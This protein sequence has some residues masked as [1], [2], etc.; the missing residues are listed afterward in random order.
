MT[1]DTISEIPVVFD[2]L[3]EALIGIVHRPQVPAVVGVL[4]VVAGGPQYRAG[5]GRGMVSLAR[6]LACNGVP[7]MRFDY[8]GLGD[9]SGDF[10]GFNHIAEDIQAAVETFRQ[11]VPQMKSVVIWG[12]C[13]AASGA[14][15]HAWKIPGVDSL[16][17]GNPWVSTDKIRSAVQR[18]HYLQRLGEKQFWQKLFRFEYN[19][20]AYAK[21]GMQKVVARFS[22]L[23]STRRTPTAK[24]GSNADTAGNPIDR[25]LDGLG[26]FGGPVLFLM[27]GRSLVSNEFDELISGD[28]AW[29]AVYK[30]PTCKRIDLPNADQTFSDNAARERVNQIIL[31]WVAELDGR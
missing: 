26:R 9:S 21:A 17:L 18:K 13:D 20:L 1:Q 12:G 23:L 2:C 28:P 27:S 15:I 29:Q 4:A 14:M 22:R 16:V 25:M 5:V 7:V 11:Q 24:A 3:G 8:R 19:L 10:L 6:A 31:E 30:R